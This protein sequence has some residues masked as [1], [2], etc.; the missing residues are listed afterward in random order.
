MS[1]QHGGA[2][3]SNLN[4]NGDRDSDSHRAGAGGRPGTGLGWMPGG[5]S[6]CQCPSQASML[7]LGA[8]LSRSTGTVLHRLRPLPRAK[9]GPVTTVTFVRARP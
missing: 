2:L 5:S 3:T 7:R 9:A 4:L 6:L 1:A 8:C